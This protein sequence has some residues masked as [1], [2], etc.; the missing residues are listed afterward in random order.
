MTN[1]GQAKLEGLY[2]LTATLLIAHQ[3][4]S[5]YWQEWNLFGMG[6]GIQ[7]FVLS[8]V[9]LILVVLY[10][11]VR[12]VKAPRVGAWFGLALGAAGVA[13]FFIHG[14]FLLQGRPEFRVPA[15]VAVLCAALATS[16][17]LG[18]QCIKTLR[19]RDTA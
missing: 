8:N 16:I 19:A 17:G 1:A 7:G 11:L 4:D 12:L 5:A 13:A 9:P 2:L 18:W 3:I 6:G 14:W 15:S 10:G